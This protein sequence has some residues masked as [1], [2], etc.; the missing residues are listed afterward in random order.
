MATTHSVVLIYIIAQLISCAVGLPSEA[1][2]GVLYSA[3]APRHAVQF[4]HGLEVGIEYLNNRTNS[5]VPMRLVPL[6]IAQL[7]DRAYA[8]EPASTPTSFPAI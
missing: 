4:M 7:S 2:V 3:P 1:Q 6:E 5:V 8:L